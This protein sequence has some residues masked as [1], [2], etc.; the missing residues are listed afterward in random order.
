MRIAAGSWCSR[1]RAMNAFPNDPVPPVTN[2]TLSLMN[3]LGAMEVPCRVGREDSLHRVPIPYGRQS[4]DEDD[5]AAVTD[6]L[7]GDWLTQ[8]PAVAGFEEAVAAACD[9]PY[10]VA[11]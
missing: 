5:I 7:H 4:I 2:T 11:F 6:V 3:S 1:R 9:V 8:G 10:A